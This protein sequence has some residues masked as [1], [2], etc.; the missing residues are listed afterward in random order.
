M[1]PGLSSD[2]GHPLTVASALAFQDMRHPVPAAML[3]ACLDTA[4]GHS[5]PDNSWLHWP[6]CLVHFQ[7]Q[8]HAQIFVMDQVKVG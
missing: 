8:F 7:L 4:G 1:M 3:P 5:Q 6:S 2:I